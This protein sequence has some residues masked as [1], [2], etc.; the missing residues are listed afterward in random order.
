MMVVIII[1][2]SMFTIGKTR[3]HLHVTLALAQRGIKYHAVIHSE[4]IFKRNFTIDFRERERGKEREI[5]P[6]TLA[7]LDNALTN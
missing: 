5:E 1:H 3:E 6:P 2:N 4:P 7:Y